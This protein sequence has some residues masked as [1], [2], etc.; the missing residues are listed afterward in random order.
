[1]EEPSLTIG[2]RI[3]IKLRAHWGFG[4]AAGV[5][6]SDDAGPVLIAEQGFFGHGLEPEDIL[7]FT[8]HVS[9]AIGVEHG[10]C[11]DAVMH[12]VEVQGDRAMRVMP[13]KLERLLFA[14]GAIS[15]GTRQATTGSMSAVRTCSIAWLGSCGAREDAAQ[16]R[17][18]ADGACAPPL[19]A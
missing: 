9:D 16:P 6:V 10:G 18:A 4:K 14:E 12:A 11:G 17:V 2:T 7:P 8:V 5:V 3:T 19:N 15:S 13:V 1:M